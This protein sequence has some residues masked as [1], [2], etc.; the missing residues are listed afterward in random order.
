MKTVNVVLFAIMFAAACGLSFFVGRTTAPA[1]APAPEQ[2]DDNAGLAEMRAGGYQFINPLLECDNF[3]PSEITSLANMESQIRDYI[4]NA[5]EGQKA[6]F[7][8]VYFRDLNFG[9]W[10][11]INEKENFSPASLLKVPIM[12]AALKIAENDPAFL[13]KKILYSKH[14]DNQVVPNITDPNLLKIGN[15]YTIENLIERMIEFSDNEAKEILLANIDG[16][17]IMKVMAD[18]GINTTG[19]MSQDFISV[20]DYSG[21]FRLL[22][23][24]TYLNRNMSEKALAILSKTSFNEGL[25]A[26]LPA[27]TVISHKFGERA[28][29]D[30]NVKQLHECGI[31]YRNNSP[32]LLCIMTRGTDFSQQATILADISAIVYKS[33]GSPN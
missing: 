2:V 30:N 22:Y 11:G 10:L 31:I 7:V 6:S 18:I 29:A 16:N 9:P 25:V 5:Q 15:T 27:G 32:Y 3:R 26:G 24:A 4:S 8:S 13:Q 23:N 33:F 1:V 17:F 28:F 14:L 12:I 21:F 19:N 20:K